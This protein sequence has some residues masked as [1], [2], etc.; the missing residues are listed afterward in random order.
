MKKLIIIAL[1]NFI[2]IHFSA[3]QQKEFGWLVGT[4][5][6]KDKNIYENWK[7]AS[8]GKTLEGFSYRVKAADTIA[9]EQIRFTFEGNTFHYIPDMAGDQ[10]PV[11]F[12]ISKHNANGFV[13]ENPQHDFPKIIRYQFVKRENKDFI[14]AAIEGDGKIIP[15]I[16]ER[17]K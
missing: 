14:E 9:M 17:L 7:V 10:G 3:A 12:K 2:V 15:Y 11:D 4:W 5:K 6:L 13:A 16:F 8:D 1:L